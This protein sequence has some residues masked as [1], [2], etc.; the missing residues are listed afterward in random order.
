MSSV[1]NKLTV[2]S[3]LLV[4]TVVVGFAYGY[5][6]NIV[7]IFHGLPLSMWGGMEVLEV[8][9]IFVAPLG[10]LLGYIL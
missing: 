7:H 5:V 9:G 10:A 4:I 8:V 1:Q 3:A 2:G 6:S